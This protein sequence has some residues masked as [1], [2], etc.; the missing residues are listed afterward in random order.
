MAYRE[1]KP[2]PLLA[3]YIEAY[4]SFRTGSE[5][6]ISVHRI[7]PDTCNDLI[8]N[9]GSAV[10]S[11]DTGETLLHS[12]KTYFV[13]TKTRFSDVQYQPCA[14]LAGI[15]FKPYGIRS[16]L[17]FSLAGTQDHKAE[18]GHAES[19]F[20]DFFGRQGLDWQAKLDVFFLARRNHSD[21]LVLSVL[22]SL[23]RHR[24]ALSLAELA[25]M[26]CITERQVERIFQAQIGSSMQE[27]SKQLRLLHS[28][29]L[30]QNGKQGKTLLE[31][32]LEAGYYDHAHFS[33]DVKKYTGR[34]PA[35]FRG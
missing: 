1:Y 27:M 26:H 9:L 18:L 2:H 4:W 12:E 29:E 5:Q 14:N 6:A 3:D 13:G 33:H 35:S 24:G 8:V 16:L 21:K 23:R 10:R 15:R 11:P 20:I 31:V 30:L 32:A 22:A 25:Q 28:I 7:L 17:G 34:S 19:A